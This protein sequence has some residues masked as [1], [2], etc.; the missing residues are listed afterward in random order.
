ML[1]RCSGTPWPCFHTRSIGMCRRISV[2][3]RYALAC[4]RSATMA[5]ALP[6]T[7]CCRDPTATEKPI[8]GAMGTAWNGPLSVPRL[9]ARATPSG[10]NW[11]GHWSFWKHLTA[12]MTGCSPW[13]ATLSS[14]IWTSLWTPCCTDSRLARRHGESLSWTPM[15]TSCSPRTA[16]GWPEATGSCATQRLDASS[17]VRPWGQTTHR[18]TPTW[19]MICATSSPCS[20]TWCDQECRCHCRLS[21]LLHRAHLQVHPHS[22]PILVTCRVCTWCPRSCCSVRI[23]M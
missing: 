10:G 3:L 21:S 9:L 18:G 2:M 5:P 12:P 16:G 17:S 19:V 13:I 15:C 6:C 11:R 22:G 7:G 8:V 4:S 23:H 14:S 20:G 1:Q